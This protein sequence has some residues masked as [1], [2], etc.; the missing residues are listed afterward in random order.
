[1]NTVTYYGGTTLCSR[2]GR[3]RPESA[4]PILSAAVTFTLQGPGR[5]RRSIFHRGAGSGLA[6]HDFSRAD[7]KYQ[8]W[9]NFWGG[10][11]TA[12]RRGAYPGS[13]PIEDGRARSPHFRP[14]RISLKH[15]RCL[16]LS[17]QDYRAPG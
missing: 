4:T 15:S 2:R 12:K 14:T 5:V 11:I 1:M 7:R 13:T 17:M 6:I 10:A 9:L 3:A 16:Y 8:S